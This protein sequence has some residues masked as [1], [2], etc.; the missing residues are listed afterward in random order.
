VARDSAT[1]EDL[2]RSEQLYMRNKTLYFINVIG[3]ATR[4]KELPFR[5]EIF[6]PHIEP[7][8]EHLDYEYVAPVA[9]TNEG[10]TTPYVSLIA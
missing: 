5:F 4:P 1:G 2:A 3:D 10:E 9:P 7:S 8:T 6:P